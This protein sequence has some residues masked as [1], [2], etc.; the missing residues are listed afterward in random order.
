MCLELAWP[1][2]LMSD[3]YLGVVMYG[4]NSK[5]AITKG[6]RSS[7]L[8]GAFAAVALVGATLGVWHQQ[9]NKSSISKNELFVNGT[10][11]RVIETPMGHTPEAVNFDP[12]I[13]K[14]VATLLSPRLLPLDLVLVGTRIRDSWMQMAFRNKASVEDGLSI[15]FLKGATS[16]S[17]FYPDSAP[18]INLRVHGDSGYCIRGGNTASGWNAA[19]D[20]TS[21]G[22][23][24]R[25]GSYVMHASGLNMSCDDLLIIA[26][27]IPR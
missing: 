7:A 3:D 27:S 16:D 23:T 13:S 18:R 12:V 14:P 17:Y 6:A 10:V 24:S 19:L 11:T 9:A 22:W 26:E 4:N 25:N 21:M 8:Y 20:V 5:E 15:E 2:V 1:D